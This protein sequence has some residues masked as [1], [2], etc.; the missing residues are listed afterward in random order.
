MPQDVY[1]DFYLYMYFIDDCWEVDLDRKWDEYFSDPKVEGVN[2]TVT[3]QTKVAIVE[4]RFNSL[5][6]EIVRFKKRL[7][8]DECQVASWY[9]IMMQCGPELKPVGSSFRLYGTKRRVVLLTSYFKG[10]I[11][12]SLR[13]SHHLDFI[14]FYG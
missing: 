4:N 13:L 1:K 5:W 2:T 9:K 10:D 11:G 7:T 3:H 8:M 14:L 12:G 6:Q